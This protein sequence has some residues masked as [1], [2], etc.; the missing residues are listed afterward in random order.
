M[1]KF[2]V[3]YPD[4]AFNGQYWE[5]VGGRWE[6]ELVKLPDKFTAEDVILE[7]RRIWALDPKYKCQGEHRDGVPVIVDKLDP[8][9]IEVYKVL[10]EEEERQNKCDL[11][12]YLEEVD[13][14]EAEGD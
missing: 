12:L 9:R 1:R 5:E 6:E 7:L 13:E 8:H 14:D 10:T 11:V 4:M 2:Q 3:R